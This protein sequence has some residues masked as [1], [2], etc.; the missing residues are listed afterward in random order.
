MRLE[1]HA[2]PRPTVAAVHPSGGIEMST[3]SDHERPAPASLERLTAVLGWWLGPD[4]PAPGAPGVDLHRLREATLQLQEVMRDCSRNQLDCCV[5]TNRRLAG[6]LAKLAQTPTLGALMARQAEIAT[7]L[8]EATAAQLR[9]LADAA[10][11]THR[12]CAA[13]VDES[14]AE[15][16]PAAGAVTAPDPEIGRASSAA[17]AAPPRPAAKPVAAGA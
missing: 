9:A 4:A 12:C 6:A 14:S 8:M 13:L 1:S 10:E 15:D 5:T 17:R 2:P 11:G 7:I 16:E 3:A